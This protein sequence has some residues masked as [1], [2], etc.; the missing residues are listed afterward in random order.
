M[1]FEATRELLNPLSAIFA[2][3]TKLI[4]WAN[5]GS[6]LAPELAAVYSH[7]VSI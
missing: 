7:A 1:Q 3:K 2:L 4:I 5:D 6:R